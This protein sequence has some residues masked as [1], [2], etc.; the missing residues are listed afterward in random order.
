[1]EQVGLFDPSYRSGSDSEWFF[2]AKDMGIP[3][4]VLPDVL[5]LRTIHEHNQSHDTAT[6]NRE[7]LQMVH[8][9]LK[10]RQERA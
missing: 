5:L 1:M 6:A 7:L 10:K 4:R 9:S 8:A 3:M 2:R